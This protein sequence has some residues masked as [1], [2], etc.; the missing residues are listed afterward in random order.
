M[1]KSHIIYLLEK[2]KSHERFSLCLHV[3]L[4]RVCMH[5]FIMLLVMKGSL[6]QILIISLLWGLRFWHNYSESEE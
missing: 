5:T 3:K 1:D 2:L 4:G 6:I